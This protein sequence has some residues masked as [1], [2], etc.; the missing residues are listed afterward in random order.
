MKISNWFDAVSILILFWHKETRAFYFAN[1]ASGKLGYTDFIDTKP[2]KAAIVDWWLAYP[3]LGILAA[4][5]VIANLRAFN[6][7]R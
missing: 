3:R 1:A 7:W 5:V 2:S 6:I 4:L